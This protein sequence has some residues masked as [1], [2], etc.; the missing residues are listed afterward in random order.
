MVVKGS[1]RYRV[2]EIGSGQLNI[3]NGQIHI[4]SHIPAPSPHKDGTVKGDGIR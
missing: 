2:V 1:L 4:P 3:S